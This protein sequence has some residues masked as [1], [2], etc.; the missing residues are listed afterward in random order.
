MTNNYVIDYGDEMIGQ[1]YDILAYVKKQMTTAIDSDDSDA[2]EML[3]FQYELIQEL[4]QYDDGD[5]VQ[6]IW[7][8]MGAWEIHRLVREAE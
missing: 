3:S 6:C 5:L 7:N 2:M 8:P 1:A 4:K